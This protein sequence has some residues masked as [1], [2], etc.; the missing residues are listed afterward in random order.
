MDKI[1][2]IN[3]LKQY[4]NKKTERVIKSKVFLFGAT[5]WSYLA[6]CWPVLNYMCKKN[7]KHLEIDKFII[8][9]FPLQR[10]ITFL[11]DLFFV[12][13]SFVLV[14]ICILVSLIG[15]RSI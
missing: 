10:H 15:N 13:I 7:I 8:I 9:T 14:T 5:I 1:E 4:S 2:V 11:K 6:R 12:F 3:V